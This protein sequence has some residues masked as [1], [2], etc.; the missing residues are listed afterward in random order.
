VDI[1]EDREPGAAR[2]AARP[3]AGQ[4]RRSGPRPIRS[5]VPAAPED[6][7]EAPPLTDDQRRK[8]AERCMSTAIWHLAQGPRTQKQLRD[9]MAKHDAPADIIDT[10][11]ERLVEMR[12]VDDA[13]FAEMYT[14]SRFE[15]Q[16][17]GRGRIRQDLR[18]KGVAD[19]I[20][21]EVLDG[22]DPDD[23]AAN[24]LA[25]VERK[26]PSTKSLDRQKRVNRLVG[27]LQRKGYGS[28]AYQVVR[29]ALAREGEEADELLPS[30]P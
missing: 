8:V 9:A 17:Q 4:Q 20:V 10:T 11:L 15:G 14:R 28:I 6:G 21:A 19:D 18:R 2:K 26:L 1:D 27:M 12:Y 3:R 7:S 5:W 30:T 13:S 16:R 25:L 24:A 22:L 29:D 23:E